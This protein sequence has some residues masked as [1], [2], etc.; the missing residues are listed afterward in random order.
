MLALLLKLLLH[1]VICVL[2][3]CLSCF[4]CVKSKAFPTISVDYDW[5]KIT[6]LNYINFLFPVSSAICLF[7][8]PFSLELLFLELG[9]KSS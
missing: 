9:P 6:N 5:I 2:F 1:T 7:S 4:N 8:L 3:L